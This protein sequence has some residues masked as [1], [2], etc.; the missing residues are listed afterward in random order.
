M[1]YGF[2]SFL[3]PVIAIVVALARKGNSK[4]LRKTLRAKTIE[5]AIKKRRLRAITLK[6]IL[7]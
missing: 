7:R 1:G 4:K 5:K 3:P 2:F 6:A